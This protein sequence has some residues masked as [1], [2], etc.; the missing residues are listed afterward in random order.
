MSKQPQDTG[1][2]PSMDSI[3][4]QALKT[5]HDNHSDGDLAIIQAFTQLEALIQQRELDAF[6]RGQRVGQYQAADRMYGS[7]TQMWLF[8]DDA[9]P[10]LNSPERADIILKDC[11]KYLNHNRKVYYAYVKELE[12]QRNKELGG[13]L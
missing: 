10:V 8:K 1:A 7:I 2:V 5:F 13:K 6:K 11:E 3:K 4:R 9:S 12:R